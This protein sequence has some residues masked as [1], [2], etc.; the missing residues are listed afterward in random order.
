M[1]WSDEPENEERSE[2]WDSMVGDVY[3][4][5]ESLTER[6]GENQTAGVISSARFLIEQVKRLHEESGVLHLPSFPVIDIASD[7]DLVGRLAEEYFD[8]ED[9]NHEVEERKTQVTFTAVG[10]AA[11]ASARPLEDAVGRAACEFDAV[12]E[13]SAEALVELA[14]TAAVFAEWSHIY[15]EAALGYYEVMGCMPDGASCSGTLEDMYQWEQVEQ[16][17][18]DIQ[19]SL[20]ARVAG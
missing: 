9:D 8:E 7:A 5:I 10:H 1:S 4:T 18:A 2:E 16:L 14:D 12:G 20:V 6:F 15:V 19:A 3:S 17:R 13:S 11:I